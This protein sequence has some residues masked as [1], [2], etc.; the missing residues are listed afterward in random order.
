MVTERWNRHQE[1]AH[2]SLG[3]IFGENISLCVLYKVL[4]RLSFVDLIFAHCLW[5]NRQTWFLWVSGFTPLP[6]FSQLFPHLRPHVFSFM[7][8]IHTHLP[9]LVCRAILNV[10]ISCL[11]H[12]MPF[13]VS[14]S[15]FSCVIV[16]RSLAATSVG[17]LVMS[18][19]K[20][21]LGRAQSPSIWTSRFVASGLLWSWP[22][23]FMTV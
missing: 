19:S 18:K 10:K 17:E 5:I 6:A 3:L 20:N 11:F 9:V 13:I 15:C 2:C 22:A 1:I 4:C 16:C 21:G 8:H 14:L 23:G 7:T 12:G